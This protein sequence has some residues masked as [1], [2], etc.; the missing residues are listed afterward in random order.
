LQLREYAKAAQVYSDAIRSNPEYGVIYFRL[1][2]AYVL[3][4]SPDHGRVAL[5][6]GLR[7]LPGHRAG[8]MRLR[9]ES[10]HPAVVE[11]LERTI[12][13]LQSIG[14]RE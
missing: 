11:D 6:E 8:V 12:V 3:A 1:A 4:G 5:L 14:M 13:A 10:N 7:L 2:A 9:R